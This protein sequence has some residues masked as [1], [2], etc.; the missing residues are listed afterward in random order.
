MNRQFK[1]QDPEWGEKTIFVIHEY[2][3]DG[4]IRW[5]KEWDQFRTDPELMQIG[6]LFSP[7][8]FEA[9][10]DALRGHTQPIINELGLPPHACLLKT[11]DPNLQCG[12]R[13]NCSMHDPDN[14]LGNLDE[15]PACF[16]ADIKSEEDTEVRALTARVFELWRMGFY[17]VIAPIT[18]F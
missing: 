4:L 18:E 17:I 14:C 5:Q 16:E 11:P 8:S 12:L 15:V 13:E 9:Y 2:K 10:Q 3:E 6:N 1:I 7:I